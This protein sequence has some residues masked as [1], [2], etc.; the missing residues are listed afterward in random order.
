MRT[1]DE[2]EICG[3]DYQDLEEANHRIWGFQEKVYNL[4]RLH[5]ALRRRIPE[6][7]ELTSDTRGSDGADRAVGK[8]EKNSLTPLIRRASPQG[9][10]P[11][12]PTFS[13]QESR[14]EQ[15]EKL[16]FA[17]ETAIF[18]MSLLYGS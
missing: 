4:H 18:M 8:R 1:L 17:A 3:T 5:S 2:E 10:E 13:L 6:E 7:Y 16:K 14:F 11:A 9:V 15:C 12:I